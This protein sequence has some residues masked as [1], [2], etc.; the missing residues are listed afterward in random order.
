MR[1]TGPRERYVVKNDIQIF[2][3]TKDHIDRIITGDCSEE[4]DSVSVTV[5]AELSV[6]HGAVRNKGSSSHFVTAVVPVDT[7]HTSWLGTS[8]LQ[9][10]V[11]CW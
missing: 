10:F 3:K 1:K 7:D 2:Y 4:L 8:C 5:E 9:A 6:S 11:G